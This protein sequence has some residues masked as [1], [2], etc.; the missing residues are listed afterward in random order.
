[1]NKVVYIDK[2]HYG[3]FR[4]LIDIHYFYSLLLIQFVSLADG[5]D[6]YRFI[7]MMLLYHII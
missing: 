2:T 6:M 7:F 5:T 1:M 4:I 3:N